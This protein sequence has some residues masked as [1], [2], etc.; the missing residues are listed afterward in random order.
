VTT[1]PG[2]KGGIRIDNGP[3]SDAYPFLI[4]ADN[5]GGKV[6]AS[7]RSLDTDDIEV[8]FVNSLWDQPANESPRGVA[9]AASLMQKVDG[10]P[11]ATARDTV[12]LS[13]N[14]YPGSVDKTKA[15]KYTLA[16][17]IG[18]VLTDADHIVN[19]GVWEVNLMRDNPNQSAGI[20]GSSKRWFASQQEQMFTAWPNLV[21]R[22]SDSTKEV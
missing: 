20:N 6:A 7:N 3:N 16:H 12:I 2:D 4:P 10:A 5:E 9:T 22:P 17:E 21:N 1:T 11:L 13:A 18:H 15:L 19:S 14:G 8:Y